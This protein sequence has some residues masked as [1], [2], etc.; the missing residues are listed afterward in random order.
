MPLDEINL[1]D[2]FV[3]R[4]TRIIHNDAF[5]LDHIYYGIFDEE[6]KLIHIRNGV[7]V[8]IRKDVFTEKVLRSKDRRTTEYL[9][10]SKDIEECLSSKK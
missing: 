9:S 6:N 4:H 8:N 3:Q 1:D 5:S 10:N 2:I 7:E